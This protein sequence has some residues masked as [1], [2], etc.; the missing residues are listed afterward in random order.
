[1][2][3]NLV[4]SEVKPL[5]WTFVCATTLHVRVLWILVYAQARFGHHCS[6][7]NLVESEANLLPWTFV[8]AIT[9][10][11]CVLWTYALAR[12]SHHYSSSNLVESE[13]KPLPEHTSA[14][15]L[16]MSAQAR[17]S[18]HCSSSNL[19]WTLPWTFVCATTLHVCVWACNA[20]CVYAC[21]VR[22]I[23]VCICEKYPMLMNWL[24]WSFVFIPTWCMCEQQKLG[25]VSHV[26]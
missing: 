24:I 14:L 16:W 5:A 6:R 1:M 21:V 19:S 15:L 18:Y 9:L 26:S 3:S 13:A 4:E 22:F 25:A 20:I 2:R 7:S 10:H 11:V 8:C 23:T 17:F 12:F